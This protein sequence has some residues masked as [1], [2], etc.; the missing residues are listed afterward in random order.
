LISHVSWNRLPSG[1]V[2]IAPFWPLTQLAAAPED[3][4]LKDDD[5]V[6][7]ANEVELAPA[8]DEEGAPPIDDDEVLKAAGEVVLA[9]AGFAELDA[10]VLEV[11]L[12]EDEV[13]GSSMAPITL[14]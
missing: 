7:A 10:A 12:F 1:A 13:L 14:L 2:V 6:V 4:A 8:K 5:V 11:K 9:A 3:A